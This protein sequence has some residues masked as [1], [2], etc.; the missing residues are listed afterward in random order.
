MN[1][2]SLT[3][4]FGA[5]IDNGR[6]VEDIVRHMKS[7]VDELDEE[8]SGANGPDGVVGECID[9]ILCALDAIFVNDPGITTETVE[10]LALKK[11]EKWKRRYANSVD[12]DR[13]ID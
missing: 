12:G 13:T 5:T 4:L 8:L 10:N 1:I 9:I 3:Q 2:V 7:E 11:L 6:T